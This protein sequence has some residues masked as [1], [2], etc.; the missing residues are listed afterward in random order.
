MYGL[1][2]KAVVDLVTSKFGAETWNKIKQKADVDIDVFVSMD[3]YP[4]DITYRLV[5]AASEVLG[6]TPEQVLEAFGE[7]W[8][9]YTAA[10]GY[11]PLLNASGDTLK[12]FLMNLDALHARVALTMPALKPPRFRLIDVDATTMM[13]EYHSSRK[14]LA[15]MV[16]GLLKGL[17]I[18]FK[19]EIEISH[20]PRPEHDEFTIRVH[21][22]AA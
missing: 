22:A 16:I 4:D 2:N 12:E 8:V 9:L 19:T 20:Q 14:G 6:I 13:L 7:Y 3:G 15:P 17:G 5:G 11:G 10:E 21:Q 1:V 18:R